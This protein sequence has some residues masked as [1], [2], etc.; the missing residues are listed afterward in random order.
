MEGFSCQ[1]GISRPC[2]WLWTSIISCQIFGAPRSMSE[3]TQIL[4]KAGLHNE[5]VKIRIPRFSQGVWYRAGPCR[6]VSLACCSPLKSLVGE[7][8]YGRQD[9]ISSRWK[10]WLRGIWETGWAPD[11]QWSW[12]LGERFA[13]KANGWLI[14]F[15][16][17]RRRPQAVVK[18]VVLLDYVGVNTAQIPMKVC[19]GLYATR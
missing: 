8:D 13:F 2:A 4:R 9:T 18:S 1:L 10:D 17:Q 15:Q 14:S 16:K 7:A 6:A 11:Y 19:W 5:V 3:A 12:T